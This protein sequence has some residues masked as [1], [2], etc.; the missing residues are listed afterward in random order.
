MFTFEKFNF[1]NIMKS[2]L[3]R[4]VQILLPLLIP[5]LEELIEK[6]VVDIKRKLTDGMMA[7][8]RI[9]QSQLR[10]ISDAAPLS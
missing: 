2:I 1:Y 3:K 8:S 4:L 7:E 9:I 6:A 5:V 10:R